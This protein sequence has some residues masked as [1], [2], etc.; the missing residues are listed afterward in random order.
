VPVSSATNDAVTFT[1]PDAGAMKVPVLTVPESNAVSV[2]A[3]VTDSGVD[4]AG[5][6]ELGAARNLP[7]TAPADGVCQSAAAGDVAVST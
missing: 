3:A 2:D 7:D 5:A 6:Y 1:V 4:V